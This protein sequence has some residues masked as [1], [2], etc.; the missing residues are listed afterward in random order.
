MLYIVCLLVE[1]LRI[2]LDKRIFVNSYTVRECEYI[3]EQRKKVH[4]EDSVLPFD[5]PT[6][7]FFVH[8]C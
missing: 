4:V 8:N 3:W 2:G 5:A 1:R 6:G 7:R